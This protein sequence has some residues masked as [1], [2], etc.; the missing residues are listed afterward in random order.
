MSS[1]SQTQTG[2]EGKPSNLFPVW[3][4][5]ALIVL[6]RITVDL[7]IDFTA[8]AYGISDMGEYFSRFSTPDFSRISTYLRLILQTLATAFWGTIFALIVSIVL[9]PLAARNLS[10]HPFIYRLTRE[11][12]N[13]MRAMPDLL[14]ALLFVSAI[15]LGPLAGVIALG[16]HTAGFLGKFFAESLERVDGGVYEALD[17]VGAGFV[18]TVMFAGWPSVN[19]EFIG[20]TL[21][22]LD[23]NVRTASVLGLVGAGGIGLE[24]NEALSLFRYDRASAIMI[25]IIIV[26]IIIDHASSYLRKKIN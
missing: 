24:L 3:L 11:L 6:W 7:D 9:A 12:L 15:G 19:R 4:S 10:P 18:Q 17:A 20:Y 25:L 14:L 16:I 22:I 26:I 2:L 21:Y 5:L 13:F 8:L 23:R 1:D